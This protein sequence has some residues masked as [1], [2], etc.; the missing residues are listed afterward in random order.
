MN[1]DGEEEWIYM[2]LN[3]TPI[4]DVYLGTLSRTPLE[5]GRDVPGRALVIGMVSDEWE[6]DANRV[7][8][9]CGHWPFEWASV[10]LF[11]MA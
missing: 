6:L 8:R 7:T 9:S 4:A 11:L 2:G 3:Q 5:A 1:E 10:L